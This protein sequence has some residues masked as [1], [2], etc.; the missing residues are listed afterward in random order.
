MH[1]DAS[2]LEMALVTPQSVNYLEMAPLS[3]LVGEFM[4]C[5]KKLNMKQW[6]GGV[7]LIRY[8]QQPGY[9]FLMYQNKVKCLLLPRISSATAPRSLNTHYILLLFERFMGKCSSCTSVESLEIKRIYCFLFWEGCFDG[10]IRMTQRSRAHSLIENKSIISFDSYFKIV[11]II[12]AAK[13]FSCD[14]KENA[15]GN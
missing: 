14:G 2:K 9:F 8:W 5:V 15:G 12:I 13:Y 4:H 1:L 6:A 11:N 3:A 7:S 10:P